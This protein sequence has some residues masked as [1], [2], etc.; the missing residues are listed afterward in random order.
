MGQPWQDQLK[1]AMALDFTL[2]V[3]VRLAFCFVISHC[4]VWSPV[5][6][7]VFY[8]FSQGFIDGW[9]LFVIWASTW[10]YNMMMIWVIFCGNCD[11]HLLEAWSHYLLCCFCCWSVTKTKTWRTHPE[12]MSCFQFKS[13]IQEVFDKTINYWSLLLTFASWIKDPGVQVTMVYCL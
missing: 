11:A 12:A 5:F 10:F 6:T 3:F 7:A 13:R 8:I 1:Q 9:L 4:A 2:E